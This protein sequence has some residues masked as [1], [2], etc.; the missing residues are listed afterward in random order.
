MKR[1]GNLFERI[2]E[3]DNLRLAFLKA[4]RG[5]RDRRDAQR[6]AQRLDQNLEGMT[7]QFQAGN[8]P[9]GRYQQFLIHDPKERIITAPCL[10]NACC[11]TAS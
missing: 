7:E 6:F 2:V 4:V 10:R 9:L 1:T 8:I 11:L 5:K 3:R